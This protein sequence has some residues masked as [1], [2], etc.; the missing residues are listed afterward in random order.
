M[1]ERYQWNGISVLYPENWEIQEDDESLNIESPTGAFVVLSR[2]ENID[3]ALD[4]ARK[5]M[6]QEYDEVETENLARV[7]GESLLEGITQRF[8]YL[9]LIITSHLFKLETEDQDFV[10]LLIQIQGEDRDLDRLQQVFDAIIASV[11][12]L[13]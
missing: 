1:P 3:E 12:R 8:V 10:P 13:S 11:D 2:P 4:R 9:D 6:E 7:V 5:T